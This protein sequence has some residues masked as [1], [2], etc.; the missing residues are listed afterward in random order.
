MNPKYKQNHKTGRYDE[1]HQNSAINQALLQQNIFD[2]FKKYKDQDIFDFGF[3]ILTCMLSPLDL[4]DNNISHFLTIDTLHELIEIMPSKK[5]LAK[6]ICCVLH[7]EEQLRKIAANISTNQQNIS[8]IASRVPMTNNFSCSSPIETSKTLKRSYNFSYET[9]SILTLLKEQNRYSDSCLD[10]L[11]SCLKIDPEQRITANV[12][13][14][15]EFLSDNHQ[16]LGPN[17]SLA[18]LMRLDNGS[19]HRD[20]KQLDQSMIDKQGDKFI[21]ALKVVFMNKEVRSKFE[22]MLNSS[23]TNTIDQRRLLNLEAELDIPS[24]KI[25]ERLQTEIIQ[26]KKK[27]N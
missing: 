7:S 1:D 8:S 22:S 2:T 9:K 14:S 24:W 5:I 3:T 23:Q 18:E 13:L 25:W 12:L 19:L 17:V 20:N 6:D 11:C 15:H 27:E 16:S 10:F 4:Y 21:E 26:G